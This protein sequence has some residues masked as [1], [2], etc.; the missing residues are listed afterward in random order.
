MKMAIDND[1]KKKST[2]HVILITIK[3]LMNMSFV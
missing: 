3:Q 1:Y 2:I